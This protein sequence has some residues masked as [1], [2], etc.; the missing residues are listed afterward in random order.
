MVCPE[1]RS[2]APD[3]RSPG[4]RNSR[5]ARDELARGHP[6]QFAHP[7]EQVIDGQLFARAPVYGQIG[8]LESIHVEQHRV[9]RP[10]GLE[11][12]GHGR[13]RGVREHGIDQEALAV[14]RLEREPCAHRAQLVVLRAGPVAGPPVVDQ[15][16][17]DW[18]PC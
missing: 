16:A 5:E 6:I 3:K 11:H 2:Y 4:C 9:V 10:V 15:T 1:A 7:R 17:G 14:A 12:A 18:Y 13:G 8:V